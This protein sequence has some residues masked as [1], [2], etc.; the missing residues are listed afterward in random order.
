MTQQS[1]HS[2]RH[3][4]FEL[5]RILSMMMIVLMHGIG[6]GGLG[7]TAAPG[8]FAYFIYWL[9]FMLGRVSTNCFVM[10]TGYFMWQSKTKASRLFRTEI[11]VLF[12]SLLT[13][14]I[15]LLVGS[16]SLSPGTLLCAVF[17]VTSCTYW[18]C[19]CYFILYLAI[20]LLNRIIASLSRAQY[21]FMLIVLF[22]LFSLWSTVCFWSGMA[23]VEN[24]Y[25]YVWFFVLYFT[26]AYISIYQVRMS[27]ALCLSLYFVFSLLS[28]LAR[29]FGSGIEARVRLEGM[30]DTL[31]GYQSPTVFFASICFFL[32]FQNLKIQGNR[33]KKIIL[34]IAPL[35]FGVYLLHDSDFTRTFLWEKIAL[36]RFGSLPA[37]LGYLAIAT[38]CITCA[39]YLV[40]TLYQKIYRVV[41]RKKAEGKVD[42]ITEKIYQCIEKG[43]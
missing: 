7:T 38:L 14:V 41:F 29:I 20:P 6:H 5:L 30:L 42:E 10:L 23:R 11:Q 39:G 33:T 36:S 34:A 16:V 17:P 4:G 31:G 21:R 32:F 24:G 35:S 8:T 2:S 37:S 27:S 28:V 43:E 40:D 1:D 18:F 19:S 22:L 25:S 15:G 12:Y 13:L 9:L 3:A 26:A